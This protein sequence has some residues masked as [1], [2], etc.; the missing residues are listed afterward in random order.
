MLELFDEWKFLAGLGIFLLGIYMMEESVKQL[1][2]RT[3]KVLIRRYTG[4]RVNG[5]IT[6]FIST[7]ILQSSSA[8]S[9]MILAFIGAGLMTLSNAIAVIIGAKI[10]TTLTAW[11]VALFGFKFKIDAF[12]F[13]M[14]GIGGLGL[15]FLSNSARY[16]NISKLIAAFG[17]LFLGLDFM[18]TS[19]EKFTV[20][21]DP[22]SIRHFGLWIYAIAGILLTALMQSSSATIAVVLTAIFSGIINFGQGAAM[23]VGANIG[24]TVTIFIGSIG[25]IPAKKRTAVS[26]LAFTLGTSIVI[27]PLIPFITQLLDDIFGLSGNPVLGIAAFHTLFNIAGAVIFFP[28]LPVLSSKL[29]RLFSEKQAALTRF[30]QNTNAQ[31]PEAAITAIKN[32][33]INQLYLSSLYIGRKYRLNPPDIVSGSLLGL[34]EEDIGYRDIDGLHAEI[35]SFYAKAQAFEISSREA[36]Q[37]ELLVRS[38][39]SIMNAVRNLYE[40]FEEIEEIG[41]DDQPFMIEAH[42][43]FLK[44]LEKLCGTAVKVCGAL[45]DSAITEYLSSYFKSIEDVDKEFIHACARAVSEGRILENEVTRL[46]L[47]N[48]YM[49]QS[50]RMLVFSMQNL[51][52]MS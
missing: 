30:I 42:S 33:I 1:A 6:G 21:F 39:R 52:K 12:A 29:E 5:I 34:Q 35:F 41:Q 7:A 51:I 26:S 4:T 9:L 11:I 31:V 24:T 36:V 45:N 18:K 49:T 50:A 27:Y 22:S 48:R 13:P 15:I 3:F 14:I 38:S 16:A 44:R 46:L 43:G 2:G 19:V 32:E 17:F 23:V 8:V 25:G 47:A 20:L 37:L 40:L 28:I 10:G